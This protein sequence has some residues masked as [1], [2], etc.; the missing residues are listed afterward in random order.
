MKQLFLFMSV[1]GLV[2]CAGTPP[3]WWNPSGQYSK[4]NPPAKVQPGTVRPIQPTETEIPVEEDIEATF[5]TY[6]E[7]DLA[8]L[9]EESEITEEIADEKTVAVAQP[10]ATLEK[11]TENTQ[12]SESEKFPVEE[13]LPEDGSLPRPSVLE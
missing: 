5:D 11:S 10:T 1:I 4:N 7:E 6:E 12:V 8:P 3:E 9:S 13:N 2:A